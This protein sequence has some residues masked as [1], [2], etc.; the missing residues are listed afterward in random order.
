VFTLVIDAV[1][2]ERKIDYDSSVPASRQVAARLREDIKNGVY[3]S[4]QRLPSIA[5]LVQTY[6]IARDTALKAQ[7]A[8][9]TDGLAENSPGMGLFVVRDLPGPGKQG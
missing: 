5:T 8:L 7:R 1:R 6:G 3:Q 2:V 4:G 9:I